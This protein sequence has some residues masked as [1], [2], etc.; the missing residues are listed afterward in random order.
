MN[1]LSLVSVCMCVCACTCV[2]LTAHLIIYAHSLIVPPRA[3][4][5][6]TR[7]KTPAR[8]IQ[9]TSSTPAALYN[10][11][12]AAAALFAQVNAKCALVWAHIYFSLLTCDNVF[13][14]NECLCSLYYVYLVRSG[15]DRSM[16]AHNFKWL[17]AFTPNCIGRKPTDQR[18]CGVLLCYNFNH[19]I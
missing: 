14:R 4:P 17:P 5:R 1:E 9:S 8:A 16:C 18:S 3:R 10:A 6:S 11:A 13:N 15:C 12:T 19:S 7:H 2:S